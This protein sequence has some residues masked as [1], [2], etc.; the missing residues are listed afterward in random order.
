[1]RC[2]CII[3]NYENLGAFEF[4]SYWIK[5]VIM[6][7]NVKKHYRIRWKCKEG[8]ELLDSPIAPGY[9]SVQFKKAQDM[10]LFLQRRILWKK[11]S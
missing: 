11:R 8:Y 1:M 7:D 9:T 3:K 10:F 4:E 6:F 2:G 5:G